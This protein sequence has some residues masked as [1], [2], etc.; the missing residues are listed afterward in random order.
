MPAA[1]WLF[2]TPGGPKASRLCPACSQLSPSA[3]AR[4]FAWL[5][6]GTAVKSKL[7]SV[8]P[9]ASFAAARWRWMR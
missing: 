6:V 3:S 5:T 9:G 1:R 7:S 4:T 8:L 2:P